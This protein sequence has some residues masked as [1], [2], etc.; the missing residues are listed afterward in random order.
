M[1]LG[2]HHNA[3]ELASRFTYH[4][5]K[6]GQPEKYERIREEAHELAKTL[7]EL[8]PSSRELSRALTAMDDVVFNANA[9]IARRE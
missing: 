3:A 4:P 7:V 8:C 5:P 1:P 9:A 2:P 6:E